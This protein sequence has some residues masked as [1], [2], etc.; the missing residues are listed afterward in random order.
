MSRPILVRGA[1]IIDSSDGIE[2]VGDLLLRD[3]GVVARGGSLAAPDGAL[4]VDAAGLI[5]A[6]GFV[7]L[8]THLREPGREDKETILTGT[9]AGAR[10]GFTTLCA[11]PNTEP[12]IDS[13]TIVEY[14]VR[15]AAEAGPVRVLPIGCVT[16]GRAGK[17]LADMEEL[18]RAGVIGFSD[19]GAPVPTGQLMQMALSYARELGLP[20]IDH[21][22][23]YSITR[24]LGIHDGWVASR[25]GLPGYPSAG[26]ESLIARD[27]ALAELTGGHFHAAHISTTGGAELVRQ[28]KARGLHV[29]AEVTP[30]HLAMSEEWVLG[31]HGEANAETPVALGA[32]DTNAKVSPPL[33]PL[34]D[35][36][37]MIA[38]LR[39]GTIDCIA[40]DHAPHTFAD[41]ATPFEEAAVGISELDTALGLL[42][43]LVHSGELSL[44]TLI[45]RLTA[46]PAALLG[47]RGA[48]LGTLRPGAAA[49]VVLLD[50]DA[51]WPV[52]TRDFFSK[53]KNSPLQGDRLRGKVRLTI[54]Q[55]ELA[56]DGIGIGAQ[57]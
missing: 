44:S 29:T 56:Y 8:H 28:A 39:D 2:E 3:G 4:T 47:E 25:L 41:K 14:V 31:I 50:L 5:A 34:S 38:A 1:H 46:G 33:R 53:G 52:D 35:R 55:G 20:V 18:A 49:D 26:E 54:A 16:R 40:T 19:D 10:S 13:A 32:Y 17:E 45:H 15:C 11:M 30:H 42:L 27:I 21:C 51:E 57:A 37:A 24:G 22:E 12:P 23:D 36:A 9:K 6:P 7:D 43:G 48:R